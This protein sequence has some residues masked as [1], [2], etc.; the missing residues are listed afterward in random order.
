MFEYI[1]PYIYAHTHANT[2][3]LCLSPERLSLSPSLPPSLSLSLSLSR[4]HALS[5]TH[6]HAHRSKP[7]TRWSSRRAY[8]R[9]MSWSTKY[10]CTRC[11]SEINFSKYSRV[12]LS[13]S[14]MRPLLLPPC[15][16]NMICI[17]I[18][19]YIYTSIYIY[20]CVCIYIYP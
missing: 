5:R 8:A 12:W 1:Y 9:W 11:T 19:V 20:I 13:M 6:T 15:R 3:K 10:L 7:T 16:S 4:T 2:H 14:R 17:H 18:Y